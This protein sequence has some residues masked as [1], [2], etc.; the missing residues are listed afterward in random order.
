LCLECLCLRPQS[1][2]LC[3]LLRCC[4]CWTQLRLL[5]L[6]LLLLAHRP[7]RVLCLLCWP[8]DLSIRTCLVCGDPI[9]CRCCC[10][11]LVLLWCSSFLLCFRVFTL[12]ATA[13]AVIAAAVAASATSHPTHT[14]WL[15]QLLGTF[16]VCK[17]SSLQLQGPTQALLFG[18]LG[19]T[20]VQGP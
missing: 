10:S 6:L 13:A 4:S 17:P 12:A 3:L 2:H 11:S 1:R 7:C 16:S 18:L 14:P 20:L 5:L 8:V 19:P 9:C 15:Q